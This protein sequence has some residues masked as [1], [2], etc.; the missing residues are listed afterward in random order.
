MATSEAAAVAL[1]TVLKD[2]GW[3]LL[4]E[5]GLTDYVAGCFDG[6]DL[7]DADGEVS[8]AVCQLLVEAGAAA[9]DESAAELCRAVL[10]ALTL[11]AGGA[12]A[13]A[14]AAEPEFKKLAGGPASMTQM[15]KA[16]EAAV[17]QEV[18]AGLKASTRVNVNEPLGSKVGTSNQ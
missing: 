9:D 10:Q 15:V 18:T 7:A 16:D 13:V 6:C 11:E 1:K 14:K 3:T 12:P 4:E 17:D 2:S 5:A 8:E